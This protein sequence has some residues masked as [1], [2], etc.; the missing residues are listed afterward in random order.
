MNSPSSQKRG[1]KWK[2]KVSPN[3]KQKKTTWV[4]FFYK[5][6]KF[7]SIS[8]EDYVDQ[9]PFISEEWLKQK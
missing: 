9:K 5:H 7:W 3:E 1:N 8:L 6:S 2:M 4:F